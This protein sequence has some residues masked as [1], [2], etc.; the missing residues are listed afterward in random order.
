[1]DGVVTDTARVHA[2][3]WKALFD[4]V[5]PRLGGSDLPPFDPDR[6]YRAYIDGRTREDG[7]RCFLAARGIELPEGSPD[8]GPD[9]MTVHGRAARKQQL[10]NLEIARSG[11]TVFPD[12][13]ALLSELR[14]R[15]IPT[16]LVTASRNSRPV[17]DA[18][19]LA[20]MFTT[21]VD[22]TDAVRFSLPGKPDA[23]MF[24]EAARR[25][26]VEPVNAVVLEDAVAGVKAGVAGGFG[27]VVGV[28]RTGHGEE[29]AKAGADVVVTDVTELRAMLT[30]GL[31][32]G[33]K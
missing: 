12:A 26:G 23:A 1:M 14:D 16:A 22:G 4:E 31:H 24:L 11:V 19:G 8:D 6:D 33:E 20:D 5:L 9:Q 3:A 18:V 32:T 7:I 30:D 2:A 28:D 17:L 10:F 29:L 25:L 21:V 27:L 13:V 15:G